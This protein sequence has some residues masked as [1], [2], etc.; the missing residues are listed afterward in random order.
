MGGIG[1]QFIDSIEEQFIVAPAGFLALWGQKPCGGK[2]VSLL[3]ARDQRSLRVKEPILLAFIP[4]SGHDIPPLSGAI[5]LWF[6]E[7]LSNSAFRHSTNN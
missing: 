6:L 5:Y 7:Y 1:E 3:T 2:N 4:D